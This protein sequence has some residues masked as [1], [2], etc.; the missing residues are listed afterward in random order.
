VFRLV[1][2]TSKPKLT[3]GVL[4]VQGAVREHLEALRRLGVEGRPVRTPEEIAACDAL[5]LPGGE[6]TTIGKLMAR[7]GL[8]EPVRELAASGKPLLGTCAG[9]ILMGKTVNAPAADQPSLG[10]MDIAVTRN[11]F[12]RQIDSFETDLDVKGIAGGPVRAVFIRAP[13]IQSAS[14]SVDVL[15]THEGRIVAARQRRM[16]ALS[17]HPELTSDSR[18]HEYFL[19]MR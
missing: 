13:I 8:L 7:F 10:V 17:F 18:I 16:L 15:A 11:A 4:A 1:P 5:I 14:D 2:V 9:A 6:S 19:A 3:V 12:G